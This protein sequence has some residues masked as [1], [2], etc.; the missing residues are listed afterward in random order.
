MSAE[1]ALS[2]AAS[3]TDIIC[4]FCAGAGPSVLCAEVSLAQLVT[5]LCCS[6]RF[7][8]VQIYICVG[9]YKT[10]SA[11]HLLAGVA[12]ALLHIRTLPASCV[13]FISSAKLLKPSYE[14]SV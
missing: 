11:K 4:F 6:S 1:A 12:G 13:S 10:P 2:R 8:K 9:L 3:V 14:H 7:V 5:C